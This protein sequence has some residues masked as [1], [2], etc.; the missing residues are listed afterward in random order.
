MVIGKFSIQLNIPSKDI[1]Y[2]YVIVSDIVG[3]FSGRLTDTSY[4]DFF[5]SFFGVSLAVV[6]T[7]VKC[8]TEQRFFLQKW[9]AFFCF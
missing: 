5:L 4:Q 2:L 6:K 8:L 1:E 7:D 9:L 3:I